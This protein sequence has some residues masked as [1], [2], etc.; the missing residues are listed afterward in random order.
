MN[1]TH[2]HDQA[3]FSRDPPGILPVGLKIVE[4]ELAGG[5][6]GVLPKS[7]EV[8]QQRVG[9]GITGGVGAATG[10]DSVDRAVRG[11]R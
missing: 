6:R 7:V 5:D 11:A 8:P 9:K 3:E 4:S 1:V 2:S 10:K